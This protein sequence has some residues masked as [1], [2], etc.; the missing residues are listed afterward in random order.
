MAATLKLLPTE[1]IPGDAARGWNLTDLLRR[2][3]AEHEQGDGIDDAAEAADIEAA[4]TEAPATTADDASTPTSEAERTPDLVM[5]SK[6][7]SDAPW[8]D[9]LDLA[10][11][12]TDAIRAADERIARLE[13]QNRE[14]E[15]Y[16]ETEVRS[17]HGRV[18]TADELVARAEAAKAAAEERAREAERRADAVEIWLG[19]IRD[20]LTSI[21][22]QA[23]ARLKRA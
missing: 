15:K 13:A 11:E 9:A 16:L 20:Q 14:L 10:I 22:P 2:V 3:A 1:Q 23:V 18:K 6:P 17:L 21:R 7:E 8:I 12:A 4:A 5:A 19:R